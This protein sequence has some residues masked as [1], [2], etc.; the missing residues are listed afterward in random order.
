[1]KRTISILSMALLTTMAA[2]HVVEPMADTPFVQEYHEPHSIEKGGAG[3]DVRAVAVDGSGTV[4]A[5]TRG[6]VYMLIDGQWQ[7]HPEVT[8]GQTFS[9]CPAGDTVYV[10]AWD[11]VYVASLEGAEKVD[12]FDAPIGVV[13][14]GP[15]GAVVALGPLGSWLGDDGKWRAMDADWSWAIRDVAVGVDDTLWIATGMGLYNLRSTGLRRFFEPEDIFSGSVNGVAFAPDGRL[16]AGSWGGITVLENEVCVDQITGEDGL[17]NWDVRS[18]DF[19][20]DGT[21]WAGTAMGV[22]RFRD[23]DPDWFA[24]N[25]GSN[26]S[27]R[28]SKRWLLSDDVRD[29]AFS[30]DGTAWI[31]T[32]AGVSA[33]KRR[34]MTLAEKADYYLRICRDRHVR[35]PGL[36]EK[37]WYPDPDD[38][39]KWVPRDDDNDG[40]YTS[41]YLMAEA[42]RYAV[43]KAPDAKANADEAYGALEFLQKVTETDGF[44]ARSVVPSDWTSMADMNET[45]TAEDVASRLIGDPRW[46][47]VEERWR[48][49]SDGKWYWKGDTSSDELN[50]HLMGYFFYYDLVADEEQ[51]KRV[52]EH[53]GNIIDH[54]LKNNYTLTDPIDGKRTRWGVWTPEVLLEDPDWWVESK[55]NV[56]ELLAYMR[57][58]YHVTGKDKYLREYHKLLDKYEFEEIMRRPKAHRR[59]EWSHIDDGM[60]A[61]LAPCLMMTETDPELR[62]IYLEGITWSYQMVK[63]DQ[64]PFFDFSYAAVGGKDF[65]L[66]AGVEF[67]RDQPLDLRQWVVDNSQRDDINYVR[68]PMQEPLQTSRMLPP[69]ERGVMRWDKNPWAVVSGDFSDPQGRLESNGVFWLLPYWMGRYFGYIAPP[70]E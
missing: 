8:Q 55:I 46:K 15:D 43:T 54:L 48:L 2:A 60:I 49:S 67:L 68:K 47:P 17:P 44:F 12:A 56:F 5:A 42:L 32:S 14:P 69:S 9:V 50:G 40:E 27:L 63:H 38:L 65:P 6:G 18:M 25:N 23:S 33:I 1:M 35:A 24:R 22:A 51:K 37:I 53:V 59:S 58:A 30:P 21:M 26:W 31:A 64:N 70:A 41:N 36:T 62:A 20:P 39:T 61:E 16:W 11:G 52:A 10:G 13:G 66:R 4:W 34:T 29:I 57:I 7:R 3:D 45:Y 28:H 19:A